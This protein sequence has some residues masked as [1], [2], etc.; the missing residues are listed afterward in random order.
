M[1]GIV[2]MMATDPSGFFQYDKDEF[3]NMLVVD[4]LRGAHS[5]GAFLVP[6]DKEV[7]ETDIVKVVGNPYE[8]LGYSNT[9]S[10]L[11]KMH[12]KGGVVVGHNRYATRGAVNAKNAHPF[13]EEHITLVHNGTLTNFDELKKK[14]PDADVDSQ[15][16]AQMFA[17][18]GVEETIQQINGA[19]VFVWFNKDDGTLNFVR[20]TQRPLSLALYQNRNFLV[21]ASE[22]STLRWHEDRHNTKFKSMWSLPTLEWHKYHK[23]DVTPEIIKVKDYWSRPVKSYGGYPRNNWEDDDMYAAAP[24]RVQHIQTRGKLN[25]R[26]KLAVGERVSFEV[27]DYKQNS[28]GGSFTV[29]G[30]N[31]KYPDVIF[32]AYYKG[33]TDL[34]YGDT[35]MEGDVSYISWIN[36][37]ATV[38]PYI[39]NETWHVYVFGK[40][41]EVDKEEEKDEVVE[42]WLSF[43]NNEKMQTHRY[44]QL[45]QQ[46]EHTC[47]WCRDP[48]YEANVNQQQLYTYENGQTGIEETGI[49]CP[50]CS[51]VL[52][53]SAT[54]GRC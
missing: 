3:W 23:D 33:D 24:A 49:L 32:S 19:F 5:T 1:C 14:Y 15:L 50:H 11:T 37:D 40:L 21:F 4:S 2:G 51:D 46:Q 26:I 36:P 29:Y 44:R 20:N 7:N 39:T 53:T 42:G 22:A 54:T 9:Y 28:D 10:F 38:K 16:V 13:D 12:T 31:N 45:L 43:R 6:R 17:A 41:K 25:D 47:T 48:I 30:F 52:S 27:S 8:L 35:V 34:L 18:E